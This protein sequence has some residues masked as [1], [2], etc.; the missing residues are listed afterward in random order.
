MRRTNRNHPHNSREPTGT[1]LTTDNLTPKDD[2]TRAQEREGGKSASAGPG[3]LG[4]P[5]AAPENPR[6]CGGGGGR[7]PS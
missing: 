3:G 4:W 7:L 1:P 6:R 5:R 2:P